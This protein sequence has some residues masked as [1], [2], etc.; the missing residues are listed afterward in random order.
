MQG[1]TEIRLE[2]K[3]MEVLSCLAAH[4]GEVVSK[5]TLIDEVW[6][7]EFIAENTLTGAIAKI[8]SA[9]GD[10]AHEPIYIQTISKR[11]YRLIGEV[12]M[13]QSDAEHDGRSIEAA[14]LPSF[15]AD[16]AFEEP[17]RP[18]F[19][20]R[21]S[22]LAKLNDLLEGVVE[23]RGVVAFVTGEAGTGKTALVGEFCRRAQER[24]SDLVVVT[25]ASNAATGAGDPYGPWRQVLAQ[26]SGDVEG[27]V[28]RGVLSVEAGRRLWDR[29]PVFA[30]AVASS[31]RDLVETL[32]R[33]VPL[34]QRSA[35]VAPDSPW[36]DDLHLLV[37]RRAAEPP[38]VT[39]QQGAIFLQLGQVLRK[40]AAAAPLVVVL[41][42]LH[43]ADSASIG[44]L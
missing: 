18:V 1:E 16:E 40:I 8:R 7:T 14:A 37:R 34:V 43:W 27:R 30:E 3:A 4:V 5:R 25:G 23:G 2:P 41:D 31:G 19:V 10:D 12:S 24:F 35:A 39:L 38:D 29:V 28:T 15:L 11:G 6:K 44:L 26:L 36:L 22:E 32:V 42:D 20:A 9:L 13:D 33:G 21:E 17:E